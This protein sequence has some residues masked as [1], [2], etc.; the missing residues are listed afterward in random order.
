MQE[1]TG[2]KGVLLRMLQSRSPQSGATNS[3]IV[4]AI[5]ASTAA[6]TIITT[7]TTTTIATTTITNYYD[8]SPRKGLQSKSSKNKLV[9]KRFLFF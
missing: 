9:Q 3:S 7:T 4:A 6:T 8:Y 5:V 1:S 2:G